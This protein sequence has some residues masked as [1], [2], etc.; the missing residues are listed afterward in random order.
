MKLKISL[1]FFALYI[2]LLVFTVPAHMITRFI[3]ESAGVL[4]GSVSGTIWNGKLSQ[5]DY[6]HDPLQSK[7]RSGPPLAARWA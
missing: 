2:A 1:A 4:I 7:N 5:M 6:R 3:P